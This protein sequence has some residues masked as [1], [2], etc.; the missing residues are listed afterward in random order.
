LTERAPEPRPVTFTIDLPTVT[1]AAE[2]IVDLDEELPERLP[3]VIVE[4]TL[5]VTVEIVPTEEA[6]DELVAL[7][8]HLADAHDGAFMGW[9]MG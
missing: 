3:D 7:L 6:L 4:Q 8:E 9:D 5:D 2:L 1:A